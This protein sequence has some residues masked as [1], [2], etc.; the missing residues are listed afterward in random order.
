M[1]RDEINERE[2]NNPDNWGKRLGFYHSSTDSRLWVRKPQPW[3]GRSLN[4]AKPI[5]RCRRRSNTD[6]LTP[7]EN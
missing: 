4:M 6:P 3:M 7:V 1:D 5:A 2:R